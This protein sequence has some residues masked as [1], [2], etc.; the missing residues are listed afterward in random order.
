MEQLISKKCKVLNIKQRRTS[1]MLK[2]KQSENG[3]W[4]SE[5]WTYLDTYKATIYK[6]ITFDEFDKDFWF[7]DYEEREF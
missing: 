5:N 2:I 1:S 3:Y 4:I 7:R 6:R